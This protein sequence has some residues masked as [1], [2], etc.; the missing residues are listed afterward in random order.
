MTASFNGHADIVQTL[1]EAKAEIGTREEVNTVLTAKNT[2]D[3]HTMLPHKC[4]CIQMYYRQSTMC[5]Y[6]QGGWTALHLA[7]HEGNIY[8]MRLLVN[9]AQTLVNIQT[10]V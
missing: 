6:T 9:E 2:V 5:M 8:V 4:H 1:I 10:E 7:A 3:P